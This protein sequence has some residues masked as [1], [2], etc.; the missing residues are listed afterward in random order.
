M[1][2]KEYYALT[3]SEYVDMQQGF[4]DRLCLEYEHTRA[5]CYY[6]Y[7]VNVESKHHISMQQFWPLPSDPIS[8]NEMSK[9][10]LTEK[11]TRLRANEKEVKK[12]E[13]AA[14]INKEQTNA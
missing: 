13:D 8:E 6:T 5:I 7:I 14:L 4:N 2:P 9:E 1:K 11:F 3:W 10:N 12:K